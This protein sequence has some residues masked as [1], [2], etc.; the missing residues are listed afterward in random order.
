MLG[1]QWVGTGT[2]RI[3]S[4]MAV[5]RRALDFPGGDLDFLAGDLGRIW[6][7][8][9]SGKSSLGPSNALCKDR[10]HFPAWLPV[11][12]AP[13]ALDVPNLSV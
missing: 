8:V 5:A 7:F 13:A 9:W 10:G 6:F 2:G 12:F 3:C 4:G 1:L 11:P